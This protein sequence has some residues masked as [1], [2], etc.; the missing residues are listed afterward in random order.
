MNT[1]A[2]A[3]TGD[4]D[5]FAAI[6]TRV[7]AARARW[8]EQTDPALVEAL[9]N[10]ELAAE[11]ELAELQRTLGRDQRRADAITAAAAA[12][13]VRKTADTIAAMQLRDQLAAARALAAHQTAVSPTGRL[14]GLHRYRVWA[15]RGLGGVVLAGMGYSA[16]NVQHNIAPNLGVADPLYWFSFLVEGMISVCLV[17]IMAGVPRLA[18]FGITVSRRTLTAAEC[19][20]LAL[21]IALNTF[22]H[23]RD[24]AWYEV[25]VH[26][27]APGMIAV[28]LTIHHAMATRVAAAMDRA[29]AGAPTTVVVVP[30]STV[31]PGAGAPSSTPDAPA[32]APVQVQVSAPA[33]QDPAPAPERTPDAPAPAPSRTSDP[34][35]APG[36]PAPAAPAPAPK[37]AP[38]PAP[39]ATVQVHASPAVRELAAALIA[40]GSTRLPLDKVAA[41]IAAADA[42]ADAGTNP[43]HHTR[44]A[45]AVGMHHKT[46]RDIIAAAA[47]HRTPAVTSI[48]RAHRKTAR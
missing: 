19:A 17:I 34:T 21:T 47:A 40:D 36:A 31:M 35:R 22:P 8:A 46:A 16:I 3:D 28:A 45:K 5:P 25:A 37:P 43:P 39:V 44:I 33:P 23:I 13:R 9:S 12:D 6:T 10:Q 7:D 27:V 18:E 24:A 26:S 32:P 42:A 48:T 11:R 1:R 2:H 4:P 14:A 29:E 38:A 41:V 30:A 15:G 20:L